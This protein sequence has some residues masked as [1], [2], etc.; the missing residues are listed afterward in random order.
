MSELRWRQHRDSYSTI[1]AFAS[2]GLGGGIYEIHDGGCTGCTVRYRTETRRG[3]WSTLGTGLDRHVAIA[4]AQAHN[5]QR[6][7]EA[8]Q[9]RLA[10][11]AHAQAQ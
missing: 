9:P 2:R 7:L 1:E 5:D 3:I 10:G 8:E 4:L 11:V 6:L